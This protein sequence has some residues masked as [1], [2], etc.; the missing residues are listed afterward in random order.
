MVDRPLCNFHSARLLSMILLAAS[1][2]ARFFIG[3]V[4]FMYQM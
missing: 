1:V 4:S 3:A 2:A